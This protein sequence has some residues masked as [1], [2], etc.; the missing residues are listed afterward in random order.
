MFGVPHGSV[1]IGL[2]LFVL[3]TDDVFYI[4]ASCGH[5]AHCYADDTQIYISVPVSARTTAGQQSFTINGS[6]VWNSF[7][8]HL[9]GHW[10]G[11]SII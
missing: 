3:Y 2:L 9:T 10:R 7:Y 11:S 8:E 4:I 1:L 6:T 5:I